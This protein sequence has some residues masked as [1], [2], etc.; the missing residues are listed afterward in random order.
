MDELLRQYGAAFCACPVVG[1]FAIPEDLPED[2]R[3]VVEGAISN[4]CSPEYL[5]LLLAIGCLCKRLEVAT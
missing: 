5:A 2:V 3:L 1:D 4:R